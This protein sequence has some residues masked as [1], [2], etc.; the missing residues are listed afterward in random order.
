MK[1]HYAFCAKYAQTSP[2]GTFTVFGGGLDTI[3]V[4]EFP[5]VVQ[6]LAILLNVSLDPDED[7][8]GQRIMV[9]FFDP[10]GGLLPLR[11]EFP[12]P[13]VPSSKRTRDRIPVV[14]VVNIANAC[15]PMPGRY[16][17]QVLINGENVA[18]VDL[19]LKQHESLAEGKS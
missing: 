3:E 10:E 17:F 4:Q 12:V 2:D 8:A 7:A 5:F 11:A 1:F 16:S 19:D 18:S 9:G 15:F 6:E 14:C 13:A